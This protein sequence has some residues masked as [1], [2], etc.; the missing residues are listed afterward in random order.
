VIEF[1]QRAYAQIQTEKRLDIVTGATHFLKSRAR[2]KQSPIL[3]ARYLKSND[4]IL[5]AE[6]KQEK[7]HGIP[8]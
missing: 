6:P 4:E 8:K 2:W 3:F 5:S 7:Q 1:N